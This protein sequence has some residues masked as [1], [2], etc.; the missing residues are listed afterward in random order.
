MEIINLTLCHHK[1]V[2]THSVHCV[3]KSV[4]L[5][6]MYVM[7]KHVMPHKHIMYHVLLTHQYIGPMRQ[8]CHTILVMQL[9]L[10]I[11]CFTDLRYIPCLV[12]SEVPES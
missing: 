5:L 6:L 10:A 12:V 8:C 4:L 2:T 7:G 3:D 1:Y 11:F 9:I